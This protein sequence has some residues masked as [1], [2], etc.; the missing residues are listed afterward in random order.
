MRAKVNPGLR[1]REIKK[2][3]FLEKY[4]AVLDDQHLTLFYK[5]IFSKDCVKISTQ[6]AFD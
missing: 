4:N 3:L 5:Y 2:T 1:I 6:A